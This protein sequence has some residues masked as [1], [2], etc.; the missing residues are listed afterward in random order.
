MSLTRDPAIVALREKLEQ[1]V[2][3]LSDEATEQIFTDIPAYRNAGEHLRR[4]VRAHVNAHL[5][6]SIETLG[7]DREVTREDLLFV[8]P[9]AARRG[10]R[11]SL[12]DFVQAFYV[13]ERVL[14][15]T[16]IELA[17]DDESRRAALAFASR[18]PRYFEVATTHAAEV[19][20]ETQEQ[21]A[22]TG[23]RI[24]RDLLEDLLAGRDPE[25]G[26]RLDAAHAAGLR[27]GSSFV[28]ISAI[29]NVTPADEQLLRGGAAALARAAGGTTPPLAVVR[30]NEIVLVVPLADGFPANIAPRLDDVQ[31]RLADAGL[32]LAV[33][34][35]TAVSRLASV[36]EAYREANTIRAAHGSTPG[37]F[38]LSELS[39]FEYLTL[40]PNPTA[41]RL[42]APAVHEFVA[43]DA[44]DGGPLIATLREYVA[45][46]LNARRAAENLHIHVNTAH[47][48]LSR[49][50]E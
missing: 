30:Q 25:P 50:A 26:P 40:R 38:A 16:A 4:D 14:W 15:D 10:K 18:L 7:A 43:Q 41:S 28:V 6:A 19:Y 12:S 5:R 1:R 48:R 37:V 23:E 8:R 20:L 42:I 45:C 21:L 3:E 46:D 9:H 49:I 11:V 22:A 24:R 33:A 17:D 35:S 36:P 44:Q 47:Y 29:P 31:H 39:A 13:G 32:P 2:E 27:D 34:V